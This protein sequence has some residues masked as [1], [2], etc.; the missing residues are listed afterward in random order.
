MK[1][2]SKLK[3]KNDSRLIEYSPTQK[4]LDENF[5]AQAVWECLKNNDPQGVMEVIEAH[6]EAVNKVKAAQHVE[7]SRATM[8]HAFK[9]KNPT[10]KTLAKL[11][12]CCA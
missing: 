2:S 10:V 3:L 12:N 5:I 9:S 4:L 8:Y 11:V 7:L 1:T 6:L